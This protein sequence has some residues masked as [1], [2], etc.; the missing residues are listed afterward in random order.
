MKKDTFNQEIRAEAFRLWLALEKN[1]RKVKIGNQVVYS[2]AIAIGIVVVALLIAQLTPDW[3]ND[4]STQYMIGAVAIVVVLFSIIE[5]TIVSKSKKPLTKE[6]WL[7]G[8]YRHFRG[9][10]IAHVMDNLWLKYQKDIEYWRSNNCYEKDFYLRLAA[11]F[12]NW[13]DLGGIRQLDFVLRKGAIEKME[14]SW[15]EV[16]IDHLE[17]IGSF[18]DIEDNYFFGPKE[19]D[20]QIQRM[21]EIIK[22]PY[23]EIKKTCG[24]DKMV[25]LI[26][27]L[28]KL[29]EIVERIPK[30]LEN[31]KNEIAYY[32]RLHT[33]ELSEMY[34]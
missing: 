32:S 13:I 15:I 18:L 22:M 7:T 28:L 30:F 19:I 21:Y 20:S 5:L 31:R 1:Q 24:K 10:F 14:K 11:N 23:Q 8:F 16:A 33:V 3:L 12:R 9:P 17:R 27:E 26:E 25:L 29:S 6:N 2:L 34:N 4:R